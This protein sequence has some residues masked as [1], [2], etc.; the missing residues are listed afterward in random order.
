V[1]KSLFI[2]ARPST[3]LWGYRYAL[4][5]FYSGT[6]A[7]GSFPY[8]ESLFSKAGTLSDLKVNIHTSNNS[9]N[10]Q[11]NTE[12][13]GSSGNLVVTLPGSTTGLFSDLT[14]TDSISVGD[15]VR[16]E[17]DLLSGLDTPISNGMSTVFETASGI[18]YPYIST[19]SETNPSNGNYWT[20]IGSGKIPGNGVGKRTRFPVAATV[21]NLLLHVSINARTDVCTFTSQINGSTGSLSVSIPSATTGEFSNTTDSDSLSVNDEYIFQ[22]N[23]LGSG[24]FTTQGYSASYEMDES[25]LFIVTHRG[26]TD[27]SLPES[28]PKYLALFEETDSLETTESSSQIY[29]PDRLKTN[30]LQIRII[31]NNTNTGELR[32]RINGAN[33]NQ[34]VSIP[35]GTTGWI[36]DTTNIDYLSPGDLVNYS[37]VKTTS[38]T[39]T[40]GGVVMAATLMT[41]VRSSNTNSDVTGTAIS[42]TAPTGTKIGDVVVVS[43]HVNGNTTIVDNNGS[44]PFTEDINDYQPNSSSGHTVSIFSRRIEAGDPSTYSFTSGATGRWSIVAT[45]FSNPHPTDIYD[46]APSTSNAAAVNDSSSANI[47][48]P[49]ITTTTDNAIHVVCAYWDTGNYDSITEPSGYANLGEINNQPQGMSYKLITTA[50]ATGDQL[51]TSTESNPRAALS[52]SIK[53]LQQ[54]VESPPPTEFVSP[55][56]T[57]F[58]IV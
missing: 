52:F 39:L 38:N 55:L 49:S 19:G 21:K 29:I 25:F 44:T 51:Y 57:F 2:H 15:R 14:H 26:G 48:A 54:E 50:G 8:R 34:V 6:S 27:I 23:M 58:N 36:E 46:I 1:G 22:L 37:L 31:T 5:G 18:V 33:G 24:N 30:N 43:V 35:S 10:W 4:T 7:S 42:V 20:L 9:G 17:V 45:T 56:P 40:Y 53:D 16:Y 12:I 11:V 3:N 41:S 13:N 47:T 32:L 28:T